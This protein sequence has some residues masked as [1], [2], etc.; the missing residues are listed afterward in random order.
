MIRIV[1]PLS[2]ALGCHSGPR[3]AVD[4]LP[5]TRR[6]GIRSEGDYVLVIKE[7]RVSVGLAEAR[8]I[9]LSEAREATSRLARA[10]Q[11]CVD[12]EHIVDGAARVVLFL[13]PSGAV[14]KDAIVRVEPLEAT[15]GA[16]LCVIPPAKELAFSSSRDE[17]RGIAFELLWGAAPKMQ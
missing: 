17:Q 12:R 1:A 14:R 15:H 4:P 10:V 9:E 7:P 2:L 13:E 6:T 16:I 11:V 8:G 5:T 3:T